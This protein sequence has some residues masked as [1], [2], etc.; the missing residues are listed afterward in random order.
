MLASILKVSS[1]VCIFQIHETFCNE[2]DM[3]MWDNL[4]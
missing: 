4:F 3:R 2:D 1:G